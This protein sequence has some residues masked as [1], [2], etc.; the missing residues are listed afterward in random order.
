MAATPRQIDWLMNWVAVVLWMKPTCIYTFLPQVDEGLR[1]LASFLATVDP[2]Q[3]WGGLALVDLGATESSKAAAAD[4]V[5]SQDVLWC[6]K[7]CL[8]GKCSAAGGISSDA[9]KKGKD[10]GKDKG[11]VSKQAEQLQA[12]TAK[13]KAQDAEISLLRKYIKAKGLPVPPST[14]G[15]ALSSSGSL[16]AGRGGSS[17]SGGLAGQLLAKTGSGKGALSGSGTW[18]GLLSSGGATVHPEPTT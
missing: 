17:S 2:T 7:A 3:T 13:W 9:A 10:K 18:K 5:V 12:L 11:K 1:Q 4:A 16:G 15:A 14:L 8:A 6:C